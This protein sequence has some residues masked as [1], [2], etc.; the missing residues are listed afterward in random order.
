MMSN[1]KAEVGDWVMSG[2][3]KYQ[4]VEVWLNYYKVD[5]GDNKVQGLLHVRDCVVVDEEDENEFVFEIN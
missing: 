2:L 4:V 1:R 3:Q 5:R